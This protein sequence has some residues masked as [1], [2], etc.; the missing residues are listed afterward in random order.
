MDGWFGNAAS[1]NHLSSDMHQS[2]EESACCD[3]NG[4]GTYFYT[5]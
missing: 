4:L 5:P 2:V 3:N 1:F